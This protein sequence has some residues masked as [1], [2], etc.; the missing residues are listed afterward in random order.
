MNYAPLITSFNKY[1]SL[2]QI[3]IDII[4]SKF[5]HRKYLKDEYIVRH[6]EVCKYRS[7]IIKGSLKKY[8]LDKDGNEQILQLSMENHWSMEFNSFLNQVP[9]A[10][11]I[12]CVD[13]LE[14]LQISFQNLENLYL[15]APIINVFFRKIFGTGLILAHDRIVKKLNLTAKEQYLDFLE[16][17]PNI[18]ERFPQYMIASYLG[19]TKEF[20]SK[21][22]KEIKNE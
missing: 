17:R 18:E 14:V 5:E 20:L 1:V 8:F 13:E 16:N 11:N 19:F 12:Q 2:S 7:F 9:A 6:S 4:C 21:I 22:K 10:Y 15:E 3:D